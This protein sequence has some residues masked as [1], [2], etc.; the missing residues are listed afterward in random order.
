[1]KPMLQ[2][3]RPE[4]C[5][6]DLKL[7][8]WLANELTDETL[9]AA[10]SHVEGCAACAERK[11]ELDEQW[12]SF[13]VPLVPMP[14]A[15]AEA[16]T[17]GSAR[18]WAPLGALA[19]AATALVWFQVEPTGERSKGSLDLGF[20]VNHAGEVRRGE[21]G[22]KLFPGDQVQFEVTS[23]QPMFLTIVSRDGAGKISTYA[24]ERIDAGVDQTLSTAV[25]LDGTLG[26]EKVWGVA[27][28]EFTA[29]EV[30]QRDLFED[31]HVEGCLLAELQWEKVS[32]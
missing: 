12:R 16:K 6:S 21:P 32:P 8:Q 5:L 4:G 24:A 26:P 19:M 28:E 3:S 2:R 22:E 13:A 14:E 30:L 20:Y 27:C 29:A 9:A 31:G 11:R 10:Q 18:W 23:K 25:E 17:K 7:D 1:M 15:P